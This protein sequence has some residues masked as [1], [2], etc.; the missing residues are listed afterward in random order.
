[1]KFSRA[2]A[3]LLSRRRTPA[4]AD[5]H[6]RMGVIAGVLFVLTAGGPASAQQPFSFDSAFGRLPKSVV[7]LNYEISIAP[8]PQHLSLSGRESV[9]LDFRQASR[10]I[11]FNSLNETLNQVRFDGRPVASVSSDD[12]QQLTTVTL[13][14][15]ASP[16]RHTLTF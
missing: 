12:K 8:D 9:A 10:T 1:M 2:N 16:G 14:K 6:G 11:V 13:A 5:S 4:R 3:L 7:P 15:P